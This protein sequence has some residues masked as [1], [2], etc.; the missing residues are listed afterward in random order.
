MSG[1]EILDEG[2]TAKEVGRR[3]NRKAEQNNIERKNMKILDL[4]LLKKHG[5][6]IS[7][8]IDLFKKNYMAE[9]ANK[10]CS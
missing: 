4:T 10:S 1:E 5:T 2:K 7:H 3:K 8:L 9:V 6:L